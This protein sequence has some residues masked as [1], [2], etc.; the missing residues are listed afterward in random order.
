MSSDVFIIVYEF[1]SAVYYLSPIKVPS[2]IAKSVLMA[3][4][5]LLSYSISR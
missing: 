1:L 5:D 2:D 3:S 4:D